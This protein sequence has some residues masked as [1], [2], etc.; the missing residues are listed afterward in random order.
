MTSSRNSLAFLEGE[1]VSQQ[2]TRGLQMALGVF[3]L[4]LVGATW[5]LWT[6]LDDFPIVPLLSAALRVPHAVGWLN[7]G[8]LVASLAATVWL[9][10]TQSGELPSRW[11]TV[12]L[13]LLAAVLAAMFVGN[14]H[15]LQAW[16]VQFTATAVVLAALPPR[17]AFALL[18]W[19][20]VSVYFWSA[21]AK[22]DHTFAH[23][24]GQQFL[25]AACGL[26]GVDATGWSVN[27]RVGAALAFPAAELL[28]ALGLS[29]PL[30][31]HT[32]LR[33]VALGVAATMHVL[34][35]LVLSPLG[36]DHQPGVMLWNGWFLVQNAL[37]FGFPGRVGDASAQP[38]LA[39]A[40]S[41]GAM[42]ELCEVVVEWAIAVMIFAPALSLVGRLDHWL[43]WGLYAPNN[44]RAQLFLPRDAV[45]ALPPALQHC[46][47]TAPGEA[48]WAQVRLEQWSLESLG[49][50]IYPQDR[51]QLAVADAILRRFHRKGEFRIVVESTADRITGARRREVIEN[52]RQLLEAQRR[53]F[54]NAF[55]G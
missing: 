34:L 16:A 8:L 20:T 29:L 33:R 15:R 2:R 1:A 30:A 9:G 50:P 10:A 49:A 21:V 3:G 41:T 18:R 31:R 27:T 52:R 17:R 38:D 7:L 40:P 13:L 5:R 46:C 14:Q 39:S 36:L 19:L 32:V 25:D 12:N 45:A 4:L 22:L 23:T 35:I 28:I 37:L 44:S 24:L 54:F 26:V 53:F 48:E 51:F 6:P 11:A 43:A 55:A 47:T 42:K